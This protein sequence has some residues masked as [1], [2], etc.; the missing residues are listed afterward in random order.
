MPA[1]WRT[2]IPLVVVV[3]VLAGALAWMFLGQDDE[4]SAGNGK[5]QGQGQGQ[6]QGTT[7]P[8][9]TS[10][11][12]PGQGKD[13]GL[14]APIVGDYVLYGTP[15]TNGAMKAL[16]QGVEAANPEANVEIVA[17]P[18]LDL[19]EQIVN[20][21]RPGAILAPQ[22]AMDAIKGVS[23][24]VG[25]PEPLG[26]NLFVVVVPK[27]NPKGI[28]GVA[29]LAAGTDLRVTACGPQSPYGNFAQL[30]LDSAD[31]EVAEGVVGSGCAN[32]AVKQVAAGE[33]DAALV[34]RTAKNRTVQSVPVPEEDNVIV[35]I[36]IAQVRDD[37]GAAGLV[38]YAQ[39]EAGSSI[40]TD[41]GFQP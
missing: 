14:D 5:G 28:E 2:A 1:K 4:P 23:G 36:E 34:M 39:S 7:Q 22:G 17:A 18:V 31:V 33:L 15:P 16:K 19:I 40:L 29:D 8:V 32:K 10:S 21:P 9:S 30:V 26:R 41:R 24:D 6:G 13:T 20:D 27:G 25:S 3:V 37:E 38:T 11:T 35:S 12:I